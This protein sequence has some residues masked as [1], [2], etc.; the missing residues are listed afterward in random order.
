VIEQAI[1]TVTDTAEQAMELAFDAVREATTLASGA[2]ERVRASGLVDKVRDG[3]LVER[4]RH[5]KRNL[6]R[7][8]RKLQKQAR[9]LSKSSTGTKRRRRVPRMAVLAGLGG[10]AALAYYLRRRAQRDEMFQPGPAPDSFGAAVIEERASSNGGQP[11]ATP[12]A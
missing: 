2:A 12:G 11:V 5:Q 4:A 8:G 6:R 3:D 7:Q 10:L 1:E 9:K